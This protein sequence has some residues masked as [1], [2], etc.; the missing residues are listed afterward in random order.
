MILVS[1]MIN[2]QK[3]AEIM[4]HKNLLLQSLVAL[5]AV[6]NKILSEKRIIFKKKR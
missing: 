3:A 1:G 6:D 5:V 4:I 2:F